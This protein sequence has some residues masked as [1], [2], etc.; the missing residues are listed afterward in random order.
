MLKKL[1]WVV[2]AISIPAALS[3]GQDAPVADVAIGYSHFHIL[4]GLTIPTEGGSGSVA[5]YPNNW[6][7][8]VGDFG[9]YHG[10]PGV[11]LT[12][13]TYTFGPRLSYRKIHRFE[14]FVQA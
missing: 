11:S 4:Q 12:G 14:P 2:L 5:F 7:G 9:V 3:C 13:E 6:F 10:S 1:H 8:V